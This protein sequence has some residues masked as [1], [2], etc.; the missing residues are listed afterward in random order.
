[1]AVECVL[2]APSN[3]SYVPCCPPITMPSAEAY[4]YVCNTTTKVCLTMRLSVSLCDCLQ[5]GE[6]ARSIEKTARKVLS[7]K[8]ELSDEA[9]AAY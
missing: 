7:K 4:R 5:D 1:M 2:T 8:G 9:T 6:G 3:H